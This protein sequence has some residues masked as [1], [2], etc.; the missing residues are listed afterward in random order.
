MEGGDEICTAAILQLAATAAVA[1]AQP[2][3]A[4][5]V[6]YP[7]RPLRLIVGYPPGGGADTV[8]R[9][10]AQWLSGRLGQPVVVEHKPGASTNISIQTALS[11]APD[12]YTLVI[13]SASTDS[14]ATLFDGLPFN[15][16]RDIA[17]VA[18]LVDF[19]LA[20][21]INPSVPAGTLP[22]FIAYAKGK[23]GEISMASNGTGASAHLAL[24]LLMAMT[25]LR[26]VHV[27]YRGDVP[28]L[29]TL[30]RA[31]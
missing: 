7:T 8:S 14:N 12:G 24:E 4:A 30:S 17:P 19:P 22:E 5:A 13:L 11:S 29:P 6:D 21:V 15:F 2:R 20:L 28:A 18:G 27:P 25:G 9:I 1:P 23:P 31:M 10:M 16:L 26:L 3:A